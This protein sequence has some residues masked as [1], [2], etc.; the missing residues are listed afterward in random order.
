M[1]MAASYR[2]QE[3]QL[4]Q[5]LQ[6]LDWME[7]EL[8]CRATDL[9]LLFFGAAERFR[10]SLGDLFSAMARSLSARAA[11]DAACCM[12]EAMACVSLPRKVRDTAAALGT[13]LG[14]FHLEGQ[15][16]QLRGVRADCA[17]ILEEHTNN[18]DN[19]VRSYQTLGL[20]GGLALAILL[21]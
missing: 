6:S 2:A 3:R 21:M 9:P 5:L 7:C 12:Q 13:S 4:R 20:C 19:R 11:P 14:E 10:G 17:R 15:L 16:R 8:T 18:R 1:W